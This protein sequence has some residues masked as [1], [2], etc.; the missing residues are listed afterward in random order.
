MANSTHRSS[1]LSLQKSKSVNSEDE[2]INGMIE[3]R[4]LQQE[5]LRKIMTS[6]EGNDKVLPKTKKQ[7]SLSKK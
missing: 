3:K 2:L 7:R 1:K 4:K 5:A 6:I